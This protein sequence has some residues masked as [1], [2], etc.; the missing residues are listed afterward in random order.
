[1]QENTPTHNNGRH[2]P[3]LN[4]Q[5][6]QTPSHCQSNLYMDNKRRMLSVTRPK[7]GG[8]ST[9]MRRPRLLLF[10]LIAVRFV[11]ATDAKIGPIDQHL[12]A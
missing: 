10:W 7:H 8:K 1:V 4:E 12:P 11:P 6:M 3:G 2:R 5:V 9:H